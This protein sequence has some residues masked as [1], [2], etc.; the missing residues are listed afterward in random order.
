M[1]QHLKTAPA[2][3]FFAFGMGCLFLLAEDL[4]RCFL[5]DKLSLYAVI[6]YL[7][8]LHYKSIPYSQ[9]YSKL[10]WL[11]PLF[12]VTTAAIFNIYLKWEPDFPLWYRA[13][14]WGTDVLPKSAA[15]QHGIWTGIAW[16]LYKPLLFGA[17]YYK[18]Y[19][20]ERR[21]HMVSDSIQD[22]NIYICLWRPQT[23]KT[24]IQ[25]LVGIAVG[26][27]CIYSDGK[28]YGFRWGFPDYNA[29]PVPP[30]VIRRKFVVVNTGVQ[31]SDHIKLEL[32]QLIGKPA[33]R[34]RCRCVFVIRKVLKIIHPDLT[35]RWWEY[36]PSRFGIKILKW[37][38]SHG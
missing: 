25:S 33:G 32:N 21:Y 23:S 19:V 2:F 4:E 22:N 27:V 17:L 6:F 18:T 24:L 13:V 12:W 7:L 9:L 30:E 1:L 31:P 26:S 11:F 16:I 14:H 10:R 15:F 34:F 3:L 28:L 36:L 8:M 35:P 20:L 29:I 37:R 5:L 38:K